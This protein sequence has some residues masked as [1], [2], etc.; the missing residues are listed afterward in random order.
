MS[1]TLEQAE[2]ELQGAIEMKSYFIGLQACGRA[3][4]SVQDEIEFFTW[5]VDFWTSRIEARRK[6]LA[7]FS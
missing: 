6:A 3:K 5:A 2:E 1:A 7:S 4:R